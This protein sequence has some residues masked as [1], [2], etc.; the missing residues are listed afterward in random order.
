MDT[1]K[2]VH[3]VRSHHLSYFALPILFLFSFTVVASASP[4]I[5]VLSPKSASGG[6]PVFYEAY[7]VSA[8]CSKGVSSM[9]IYTAPG[10][11]AYKASGGHLE[12]F[13]KLKA[14]S[15]NTV[16]QAWDNCGG[17]S[18]TAVPLKVNSAAG[19]TVY[20]PVGKSDSA[21]VHFAA[22]AQN[23]ACAKGMS[24]V[25]IYTGPGVSPYTMPGAQLD[26]YVAL[27]SKGYV[28][29]VQAWDNCGHVFKSSFSLAVSGGSDGYLYG[30]YG[31]EDKGV[32]QLNI[33]ADGTMSNPNG[34]GGPPLYA[35]AG[36]F[37]MAADPG[38]W[39]VYVSANKG[40]YGFAVN[41]KNGSLTGIA[42]SP[43]AAPQAT[44]AMDPSGNFLYVTANSAM[45]N[46]ITTYRI[47]RSSGVLTPTKKTTT[48]PQGSG[49]FTI[50]NQ[51]LYLLG[52]SQPME[53]LGY[54]L[55]ASSG[56][57]RAVPG[58]PYKSLGEATASGGTQGGAKESLLVL[59]SSNEYLFAG[60]DV[61]GSDEINGEV[62]TYVINNST[63][64]LAP[65]SRPPLLAPRQNQQL[66]N[67]WADRQGKFVW[68]MWQ[69]T[70]DANSSVATYD[71]KSDGSLVPTGFVLSTP[72]A[73]AFNFLHEDGTGKHLFSFWQGSG[74][75]GEATWDV[76]NGDLVMASHVALEQSFPS[77]ASLAMQNLEAVVRKRPN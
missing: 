45:A 1:H 5:T 7:A 68:T 53:I 18:K 34:S 20:L 17:V 8:G 19:V 15:Y 14:G 64:A 33:A 62:F 13:V 27:P 71:V 29:V 77:F 22:S 10:V 65:I 41:P 44:L 12:T 56:A 3:L 50:S 16:V 48:I 60:A 39:F 57:L 74:Q 32:V 49:Q 54:A 43:F 21:P 2:R 37:S 26:A 30:S 4:V 61:S 38:G 51:Y 58:S 46:S 36:A 66:T 59:A 63:G 35:A 73:G 67:V 47:D 31:T 6:S 55:D 69:D 76:V 40:I 42:G 52:S 72:Y 11:I 23:P 28:P 75:Q 70:A 9:R 25:R 24:A